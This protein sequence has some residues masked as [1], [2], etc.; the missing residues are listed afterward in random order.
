MGL[1]KSQKLPQHILIV[2]SI[3]DLAH[4][5]GRVIELREPFVDVRI[6]AGLRATVSR[7]PEIAQPVDQDGLEPPA[8]RSG[9]TAM[10]ELAEVFRYSQQ[11]LLCEIVGITVL[12]VV[13]PHPCFQQ[14]AVQVEKPLPIVRL[15]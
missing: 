7:S 6:A 12:Y 13:L 11:N 5:T 8:K 1:G 4:L 2:L 9:L 3:P 10:F 14:G 15:G